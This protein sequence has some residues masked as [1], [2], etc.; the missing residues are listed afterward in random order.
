M[1]LSGGEEVEA[2]VE[3]GAVEG[4]AAVLE[5]MEGPGEEEGVTNEEPFGDMRLFTC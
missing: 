1:E 4:P 2:G 5:A 3:A